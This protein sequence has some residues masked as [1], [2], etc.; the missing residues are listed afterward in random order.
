MNI[1]PLMDVILALLTFF[2]MSLLLLPTDF[3]GQMGDRRETSFDL[4]PLR[5]LVRDG[6]SSTT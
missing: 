1:G 4:E 3:K 2:I 5:I 6:Y